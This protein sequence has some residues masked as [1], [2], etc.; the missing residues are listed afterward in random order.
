MIWNMYNI[1]MSI[2]F[3]LCIIVIVSLSFYSFRLKKTKT[4]VEDLLL[5]SLNVVPTESEIIKE[6]FLKF[7]SDS[8]EWAYDY[9]EEVQKAIKDFKTTVEPHIIFFDK[10]GDVLSNQRPDYDAMKTISAAYK[11]LITILPE[12]NDVTT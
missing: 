7:V 2:A 1:S 6:D 12:E 9:I 4:I 3:A 10:F 11:E 8:R 5:K